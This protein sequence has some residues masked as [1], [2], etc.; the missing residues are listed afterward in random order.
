MER[1]GV[2][3]SWN[4]ELIAALIQLFS[5]VSIGN[6]CGLV[7]NWTLSFT[8]EQCWTTLCLRTKNA[9]Y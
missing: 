4:Q 5:P 6:F 9:V 2:I 8:T 1:I 7:G 3:L